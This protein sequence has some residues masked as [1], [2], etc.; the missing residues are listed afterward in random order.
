MAS[1]VFE[2]SR[3]DSIQANGYLTDTG[4]DE[5]AS[6]TIKYPGML[7]FI[8]LKRNLFMYTGNRVAHLCYSINLKMVNNAQVC[9]SKGRLTLLD[10]FWYPTQLQTPSELLDYPLP[11]PDLDMI[12]GNGRGMV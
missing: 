6:V 5:L 4:V 2:G 11:K 8:C 12:F 3:P 7:T 9:G 10:P 1:L